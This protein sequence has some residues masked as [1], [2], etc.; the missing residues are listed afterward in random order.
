MGRL[1]VWVYLFACSQFIIATNM[2]F[3]QT[4]EE[5]LLEEQEDS[6][7]QSEL[8]EQMQELKDR[9]ID[10]NKASANALQLLP[11]LDR[12]LSLRIVEYRTKHGSFR[13]VQELRK[14][15]GFDEDLLSEIADFLTVSRQRRIDRDLRFNWRTRISERIDRPAGFE[16]GTYE[17]SSAKIYNRG[18]LRLAD[19][20]EGGF[21]LEKDS[22]ESRLDDLKLFYA[23]FT[24]TSYLTMTVGNYQ[25]QG[26]QGLVLWSPYGFSKSSN[27][28]LPL[29]KKGKGTRGYLSVD[30]NAAL[31]G[32]SATAHFHALELT[33]F[34]SRNSL[35]ATPISEGLVS[36][37][38]ESGLHRNATEQRK[39]D[40]IDETLA[41]GRLAFRPSSSAQ[42]GAT[43]YHS[44]FDKTLAE[45]D[46]ER[47]RFAFSGNLN[48]VL[49]FDWTLNALDID[50]FGELAR[51][52]NGS[53]ALLTG[54][55]FGV[56]DA[57]L[58]FLYRSYSKDFQNLHAFGFGERNG[59]TQNERGYYIG[60]RYRIASATRLN[61]YYDI[62]KFPWRSFFEPLPIAGRDFLLQV[63]HR[64]R[65][66]LSLTLRF[67][68]KTR[69]QSERLAAS[70]RLETER[71]VERRQQQFRAQLDYHLTRQI[72]L[73]TR[74]QITRNRFNGFGL[75]ASGLNE[76]GFLI[77][78]EFKIKTPKKVRLSARLSFFDTDSF[79][80]R[81]FQYEN[82]LPGVVT[83]RA[84]FGRGSRWY[85]LL[86][87]LPLP[88]VAIH[89][90][91]SET[92]RDDTR[93]IG[94]GADSI[95]GNLDRRAA[96]QLETRL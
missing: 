48:E 44:S 54:T 24:P 17:N 70:E 7:D 9:P 52:R 76:E 71:F 75:D 1:T 93:V 2:A 43:F 22:G 65:G 27:P 41:G 5:S 64:F 68:E 83:N 60:L 3:S 96:V 47:N 11:A 84:L 67:R 61:A 46:Q 82:D 72:S 95:D 55:R 10:L 4:V 79:D 23:T 63:E 89:I 25:V 49:G 74:I 69:E 50:F 18:R 94:T 36:S 78:Q 62:F 16:D 19:R 90:K 56:D 31:F 66:R 92:F 80:S 58:A 12:T 91:Y 28:T 87:Y 77:Y 59:E 14:I 32:G 57:E 26:G 39:K 8:L 42:F 34:W 53:T 6:S 35:D 81:V 51:S 13:S 86:T 73:R 29:Q 15:P 33:T 21:L 38:S 40:A 37:L 30:E 88:P 20:A 45:P 85:V